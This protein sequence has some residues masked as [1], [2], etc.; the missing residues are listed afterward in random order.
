MP[1]GIYLNAR[2][3][4]YKQ[5]AKEMNSIISDPRRY[6]EF[7]KWHGYYNFYD[8]YG[9]ENHDTYG[10]CNICAKLNKRMESQRKTVYTHITKWWNGH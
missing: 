3:L 4:G 8:T 10:I 7:F 5:L 2:T 1:D 6:Y 9:L